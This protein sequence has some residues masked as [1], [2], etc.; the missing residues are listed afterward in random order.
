VADDRVAEDLDA[1]S[2]MRAVP[3]VRARRAPPDD[4][5]GFRH[6]FGN[7]EDGPLQRASLVL[8]GGLAAGVDVNARESA[9]SANS[10]DASPACKP[11]RHLKS[12]RVLSHKPGAL[13]GTVS[14][15]SYPPCWRTHRRW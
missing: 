12:A 11:F 3:S 15:R 13:P 14:W 9:R 1:P 2:T 10:H 4:N 8:R 7:A 6:L 5:A